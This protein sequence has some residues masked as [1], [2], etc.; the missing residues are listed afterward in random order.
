MLT[1]RATLALPLA[2][3]L[4]A[5]HALAGE[6]R[7]TQQIRIIVPAAPGGTADISARLLAPF[8]QTH[9]GQPCVADNKSGAG[10]T[11]GSLEAA[12]ATPDGHTLLLGNIG[13]QAIAHSLFRNLQYRPDSFLPISGTVRGPNVLVVHPSV[14]ANTLPELVALLKK[15]PGK[16]TYGSPG[17]GQSPHLTGVWFNQATGTEA[18]HVPFRGAG[19]AAIELVAG[20][21]Q[22][23]WDNLT[24]GIQ[25]IRAGR[26]RA[27]A[28]SSADRNPQLPDVPAARE[29]MPELAQFDVNTWFGI[30]A[31]AG[32]PRHI[33]E[34]LNRA[35]HEWQQT[36]AVKARWT[37]MGG[38]SLDGSLEQ[39][40]GFVNKEIEK[41]GAVI[42]KEGLQMEVG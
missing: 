41:W 29:T 40:A 32:T 30:F 31:P 15:E 11:I 7:P 24:S 19:P 33:A 9:F 38:V 1:R 20:N 14:P 6:W 16:L 42:R 26:V 3:P 21:I 13:P 2:M 10:G 4:V 34:T 8:F 23:M 35:M 22:Y 37:E 25:Q 36:D 17:I 18:I 5:H 39:F 12:R 27:L 28:V